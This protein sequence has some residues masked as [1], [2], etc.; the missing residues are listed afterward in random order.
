MKISSEN[1]TIL[2]IFLAIP[3]GYFFPDISLSQKVIGDIFLSSLKMLIIPLIMASIFVA[4]S[5]LGDAKSLRNLGTKAI[6]YYFMTTSLAV[7]IGLIAINI[8]HIGVDAHY[9]IPTSSNEMPNI[10]H[11]SFNEFLLSFIPTNIVSSLANGSIIQ[12]IVFTSLLAVAS[13]HL[14]SEKRD[15]L[16]SFFDSLN[17]A[18][19]VIAKWVIKM[20]PLGVFSLISYIIAKEGIDVLFILSDYIFVVLIALIFHGFVTL[21]TLL[22]FLGKVKPITYFLQVKSAVLLAFSTASSS[23]TLP[24]TMKVA[25]ENGGVSKKVSGFVL[26][27]GATMNMDGTALYQSIAV[28]FMANLSGVDLS[29]SDE[30]LI[31]ATTIFA[32]VGAAGIPGAGLIMMIVVLDSVGLPHTYIPLILVVDRILDMFRTATNVWGDLVA[33]KILAT[34]SDK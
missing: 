30:V 34:S 2:A 27:L 33:T 26:P 5:G 7:L 20:T 24:V 21:P 28:L 19:M 32:S 23:A 14:E 8:S 4:I 1:L 18:M 31:F 3:F 10:K 6:F 17:E 29:I 16:Y 22:Y 25:H 9:T 12:V 11:L 13:L 15:N